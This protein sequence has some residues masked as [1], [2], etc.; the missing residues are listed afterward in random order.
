MARL[1]WERKIKN[2]YNKSIMADNLIKVDKRWNIF[3][4]LFASCFIYRQRTRKVSL[5]SLVQEGL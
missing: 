5:L 4:K 1:F 2:F 3:E